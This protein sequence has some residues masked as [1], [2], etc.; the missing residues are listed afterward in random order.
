M[1]V[2]MLYEG[3]MEVQVISE[4]Y[5]DSVEYLWS[6]VPT[7]I[8]I[9]LRVCV[10]VC[11]VGRGE[12]VGWQKMFIKFS[13]HGNSPPPNFKSGGKS[14]GEEISCF[15]K[16]TSFSALYMTVMYKVLS[17]KAPPPRYFEKF[18]QSL[19]HWRKALS[20]PQWINRIQVHYRHLKQHAFKRKKVLQVQY[21]VTNNTKTFESS[22]DFMM[23]SIKPLNYHKES[24]RYLTSV[25]MTT[26]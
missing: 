6:W 22:E 18:H 23:V 10:H 24:E 7:W 5:L 13:Y 17:E 3:P 21:E 4:G 12:W 11:V 14:C 19:R 9:W 25:V 2:E 8:F 1:F 15:R 26:K 16:K 20:I